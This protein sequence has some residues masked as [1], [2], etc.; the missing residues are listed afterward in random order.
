VNERPSLWTNIRADASEVA[1][2]VGRPEW[3]GVLSMLFASGVAIYGFFEEVGVSL[4]CTGRPP[5]G[6]NIQHAFALAFFGGLVGPVVIAVTSLASEAWAPRLWRPLLATV[7]LLWAAILELAIA[8]VAL[9]S[10]TLVQQQRACSLFGE[11]R[12]TSTAHF[13]YLYVLWA[14]PLGLILFAASRVAFEIVRA[15]RGRNSV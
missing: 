4:F 10:A 14:V 3:I 9:D 2:F 15:G 1:R 7:L 11:G 12:G 6:A 5:R 8:F 13:G